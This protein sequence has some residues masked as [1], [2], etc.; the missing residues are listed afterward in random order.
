VGSYISS[1]RQLSGAVAKSFQHPLTDPCQFNILHLA[2]GRSNAIRSFETPSTRRRQGLR[3]VRITRTG[4]QW[5]KDKKLV[6]AGAVGKSAP[7]LALSAD[8]SIVMLGA[9]NDN[10]G[11]GAAWVF[12]RSG[13]YWSQDK[14]L[15]GS[16]AA[17]KAA[18]PT[19]V[20]S[21]IVKVGRSNDDGGTGA[22][23]V[24]TR[25]GGGSDSQGLALEQMILL[26][27]GVGLVIASTIVA[28]VML[29]RY[30]ENDGHIDVEQKAP[31]RADPAGTR[32]RP[33][34]NPAPAEEPRRALAEP[35]DKEAAKATLESFVPN[36]REGTN[37]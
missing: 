7:S 35:Y 26:T 9:S 24:F 36:E 6:G 4:G 32:A 16:G 27:A 12:T 11:V 5:A 14:H 23:T 1:L 21:N 20:D 37:K 17:A 10:G 31:V 15:V 19:S 2:G 8:G 18:P 29:V 22:A 13:G 28:I 25:K 3:S 34:V 33:Q 30:R